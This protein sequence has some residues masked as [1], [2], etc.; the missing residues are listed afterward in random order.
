MAK[1]LTKRTAVEA[2]KPLP[3]RGK[4][5]EPETTLGKGP[6]SVAGKFE[7]LIGWCANCEK[8]ANSEFDHLCYNC[9]KDAEGLEYDEE[10]KLWIKKAK[11]R[12]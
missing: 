1:R 4:E 6:E 3:A 12:K 7:P 5:E 9:H 2:P 10:T 8:P 11:R